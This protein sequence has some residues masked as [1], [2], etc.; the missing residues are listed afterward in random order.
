MSVIIVMNRLGFLIGSLRMRMRQNKY[1]TY[2][3]TLG[4]GSQIVY[5]D[6]LHA[7]ISISVSS[8]SGCQD[9]FISY[10]S[11]WEGLP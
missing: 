7:S 10:V 2:M 3:I 4:V 6:C 9:C 11:I 5:I 8:I 1:I